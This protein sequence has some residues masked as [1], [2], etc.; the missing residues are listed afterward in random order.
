MTATITP[1]KDKN[2]AIP[3]IQLVLFWMY[4]IVMMIPDIVMFSSIR[5]DRSND[6]ICTN[7]SK[8][9]PF[10]II[11]WIFIYSTI[12][13][14]I[15]HFYCAQLFSHVKLFHKYQS[16]DI[17]NYQAIISLWIGT[18]YFVIGSFSVYI[19]T[20]NFDPDLE[21]RLPFFLYAS[22][23]KQIFNFIESFTIIFGLCFVY[24]QPFMM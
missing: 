7:S 3:R 6:M 5:N 2:V 14:I 24:S 4:Y 1:Q 19:F 9:G 13:L 20:E 15:H 21:N 18:F 23:A 16:K 8:P 12:H 17:V 22:L 11:D 10:D